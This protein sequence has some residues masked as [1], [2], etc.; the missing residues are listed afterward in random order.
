MH[1]GQGPTPSG[2]G[3][4]PCMEP[5]L[6]AACCEQGAMAVDMGRARHQ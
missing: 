2:V 4:F 3:P 1:D 6:F 5:G